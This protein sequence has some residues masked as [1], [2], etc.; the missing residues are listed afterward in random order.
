ML[1]ENEIKVIKEN[2][3]VL[4]VKDTLEMKVKPVKPTV[5]SNGYVV[6]MS[7]EVLRPYLQVHHVSVMNPK[8]RTDPAEAEHIARDVL[9]DECRFITHGELE[10]N[11]LHFMKFIIKE[12]KGR[13]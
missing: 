11:N 5:V 4:T 7:V 13:N 8:G 6:S 3:L 10:P 9:G 1:T 12:A 2:A